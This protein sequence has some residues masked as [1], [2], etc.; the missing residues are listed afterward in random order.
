MRKRTVKLTMRWQGTL[1]QNQS[2][3]AVRRERCCST[4][5]NWLNSSDRG[6]CVQVDV[7]NETNVSDSCFA[8][9]KPLLFGQNGFQHTED[10]LDLVAVSLKRAWDLLR[11]VEQEPRHLAKVWALA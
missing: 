6:L 1:C 11:V 2:P 7:R 9:N 5:R 4:C 8:T 10:T 3:P